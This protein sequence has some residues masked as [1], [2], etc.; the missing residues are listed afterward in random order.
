[1][2]DVASGDLIG[3]PPDGQRFVSDARTCAAVGRAQR[4]NIATFIPRNATYAFSAVRASTLPSVPSQSSCENA[5]PLARCVTLFQL[6][7]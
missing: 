5:A 1:M 7:G 2:M 3:E 6:E 4:L